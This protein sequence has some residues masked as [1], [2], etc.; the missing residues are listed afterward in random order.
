MTEAVK[1]NKK[2][3]INES[4][5]SQQL[6]FIIHETEKVF[7]YAEWWILDNDDNINQSTFTATV[8][9]Q[10]LNNS[11]SDHFWW[12]CRLMNWPMNNNQTSIKHLIASDIADTQWC[13]IENKRNSSIALNIGLDLKSCLYQKKLLLEAI[14]LSITFNNTF[15]HISNTSTSAVFDQQYHHMDCLII[16]VCSNPIERND[17]CRKH[18]GK[19]RRIAL[20]LPRICWFFVKILFFGKH[21]FE[22]TRNELIN[23]KIWN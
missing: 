20:I 4:T 6:N 11:S 21:E 23:S 19:V 12:Y 2:E 14:L 5:H 16:S 10:L 8:N 15:I 17:W 3:S 13:W 22:V 7:K 18:H 9:C 1:V